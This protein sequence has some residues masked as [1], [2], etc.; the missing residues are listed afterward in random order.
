MIT[1][2]KKAWLKYDGN[3]GM[4][5]CARRQCDSSVHVP[6]LPSCGPYM[7]KLVEASILL[8]R[9]YAAAHNLEYQPLSCVEPQ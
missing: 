6:A 1:T 7:G 4:D 3:A 8:N 5:V 9:K 2:K